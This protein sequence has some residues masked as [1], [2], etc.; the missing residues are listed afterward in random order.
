LVSTTTGRS[1]LHN[2]TSPAP[3]HP[4]GTGV[5]GKPS[6]ATGPLT[7]NNPN[8]SDLPPLAPRL[9]PPHLHPLRA[10]HST[11]PLDHHNTPHPPRLPSPGGTKDGGHHMKMT[12][13]IPPA[14]GGTTHGTLEAAPPLNNLINQ[15]LGPGLTEMTQQQPLGLTTRLRRS[16]K[17]NLTQLR[18]A[19][20]CFG[21]HDW[22][23]GTRMKRKKQLNKNS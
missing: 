6:Q 14:P 5:G 7:F 8:P 13:G 12:N 18:L 19:R 15:K 4:P 10:H 21:G 1:P 11:P 9:Q 2:L 23:G 20:Q 16:L 3:N 17:K 22:P